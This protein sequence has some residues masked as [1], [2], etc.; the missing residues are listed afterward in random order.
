[1]TLRRKAFENIVGKG[2]NAGFPTIFFTIPK[3]NFNSSLTFISSSAKAV[4]SD[5][6]KTCL[7][8][9]SKASLSYDFKF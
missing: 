3:T 4:N 7:F 6:S 8:G 9:K 2:E 1:M 5:Q